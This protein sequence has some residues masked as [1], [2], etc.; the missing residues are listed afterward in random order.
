MPDA[1]LTRPTPEP[2][3]LIRYLDIVLV[4]AALPLV[5]LAGLTM[6][7]YVVGAGAWITQRPA[8]VM[9]RASTSSDR[10]DDRGGVMQSVDASPGVGG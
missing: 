4:V 7:G 1:A 2:L 9:I 6:L 8:G 5:A 10:S 3:A